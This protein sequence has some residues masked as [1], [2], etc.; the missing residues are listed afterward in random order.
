MET[1]HTPGPWVAKHISGS[2]FAVQRF[3]IR[4]GAGLPTPIFN[5]DTSA[6]D[7]TT[8]CLSPHDANLIAAAPELLESLSNLVGLARLGAAHLGKYHAAL[9]DADAIIARATA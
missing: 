4:S 1:K 5:K 8:A 3:E 6:I 2:N 9:A 7:C